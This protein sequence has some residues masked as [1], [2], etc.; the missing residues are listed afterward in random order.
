MLAAAGLSLQIGVPGADD[1]MLNYQSTSFHD[2]LYVREVL[3]LRRAPEF[4]DWLQRMELMA[5]DGRIPPFEPRRAQ[6]AALVDRALDRGAHRRIGQRI[7]RGIGIAGLAL[8]RQFEDLGGF[9]GHVAVLIEAAQRD[10]DRRILGCDAPA[11]LE[12]I[13]RL[14]PHAVFAQTVRAGDGEDR[15]ETTRSG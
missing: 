13:K 7:E 14:R 2:Q 3:G 8:K 6:I 10:Q 9:L 5:P 11:G 15:I 1:V 12:H 4:E